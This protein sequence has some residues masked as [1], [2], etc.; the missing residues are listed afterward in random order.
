MDITAK[1][2]TGRNWF[3]DGQLSLQTIDSLSPDMLHIYTTTADLFSEFKATSVIP[4]YSFDLTHVPKGPNSYQ[5][6]AGTYLWG[7]GRAF[8]WDN[9]EA[10]TTGTLNIDGTDVA[11]V[12][13]K[14]MTWMDFQYGPG[15]ASE[16]WYSFVILL[17]NGVKITTMTLLP[18]TKYPI[19]SVATIMYPTGHHEVYTVDKN[20]HPKDPWVSPNTNVTYYK[21]YQINI[22]EKSTYLHATVAMEGGELYYPDDLSRGIKIADTFS[23]FWGTFDGEPITGWGN[24]ERMAGPNPQSI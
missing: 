14:S 21:S 4:G 5:A 16:G 24:S 10:W 22:P 23:Y 17:A 6:G 18:T 2:Y 1:T 20:F 3:N 8:A 15:F 12:P 13:E 19:G 11:V 9:P 7:V